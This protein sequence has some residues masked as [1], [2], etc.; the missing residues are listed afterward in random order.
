MPLPTVPRGLFLGCGAGR[1]QRSAEAGFAAFAFA[2]LGA[3][4]G[5]AAFAFA[6]LGAWDGFGIFGADDS[7]GADDGNTTAAALTS[8]CRL[9]AAFCCHLFSLWRA[10][11]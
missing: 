10:S 1:S 5:F 9:V 6:K 3:W 11:L 8:G 4:D 7:N 2:N